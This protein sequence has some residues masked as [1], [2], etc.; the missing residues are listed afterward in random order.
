MRRAIVAT[1]AYR[2]L[3]VLSWT[4]SSEPLVTAATSDKAAALDGHTPRRAVGVQQQ[5]RVVGPVERL[6]AVRRPQ[7]RRVVAPVERL[8]GVRRPQQRRAVALAGQQWP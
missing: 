3:A 7:Q 5:R 2:R 8:A 1:S 6:A 4:G